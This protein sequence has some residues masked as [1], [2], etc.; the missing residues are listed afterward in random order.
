MFGFLATIFAELIQDQAFGT[1]GIF[2]DEII[3]PPAF[4]A[5]HSDFFNRHSHP[6]I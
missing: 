6:A 4:G 2:W 5:G 3:P 1:P